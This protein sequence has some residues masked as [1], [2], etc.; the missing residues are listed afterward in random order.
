[1]APVVVFVGAPGAGKTAVAENVAQRLDRQFA[2]TDTE[3]EKLA[4]LSITDLFVD[5]GE[6]GFRRRERDAVVAALSQ[7]DEVLA[8]GGGAVVDDNTRAD[9]AELTVVW[10]QVGATEAA[11]RAGISGPRPL[12]LGNVRTTWLG[13]LRDRE[14]LYREVATYEVDTNRRSVDEVAEEVAQLLADSS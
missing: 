10:L 6:A 7:H 13:Q 14:E 1:M 2:D 9:L 5:E 8:L 3:V 4:G 11:K 12:L